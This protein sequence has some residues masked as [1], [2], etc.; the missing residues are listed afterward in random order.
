M[1]EFNSCSSDTKG[2]LVGM[3][4][5]QHHGARKQSLLGDLE[6]FIYTK[7]METSN[8]NNKEFDVL[9]M[10]C[11]GAL[12]NCPLLLHH[13]PKCHFNANPELACIEIEIVMATNQS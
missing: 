5:D 9:H 13:Q 3:V 2:L 10:N 1:S 8:G 11:Q 7:I 4:K 12:K 6:A